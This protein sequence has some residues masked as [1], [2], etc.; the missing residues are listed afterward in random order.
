MPRRKTR[1]LETALRDATRHCRRKGFDTR[2]PE[3][4]SAVNFGVFTAFREH[5]GPKNF[6]TFACRC[7]EIECLHH[8]LN[9]WWSLIDYELAAKDHR[10]VANF[11][12]G[13][14]FATLPWSRLH[15]EAYDYGLT[16]FRGDHYRCDGIPRGC[17]AVSRETFTRLLGASS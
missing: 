1:D 17:V 15:D 7:A 13:V 5:T 2:D 10:V 11:S 6:V 9:R 14:R 3:V 4:L 12:D 8:V 16:D